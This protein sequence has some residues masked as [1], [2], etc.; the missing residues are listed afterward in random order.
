MLF[1]WIYEIMLEMKNGHPKWNVRKPKEQQPTCVYPSRRLPMKF[2]STAMGELQ[3]DLSLD[4]SRIRSGY[5]TRFVGLLIE[6]AV[7]SNS[8]VLF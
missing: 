6:Y 3:L 7:S 8:T 5:R 1:G 2:I 4:L